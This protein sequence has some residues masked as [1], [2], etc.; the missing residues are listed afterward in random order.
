[1]QIYLI[2]HLKTQG[3][4]E[5]RYIGR[6]DE[7][8][9]QTPEQDAR[10]REM[11][12]TLPDVEKVVASPMK[13][14][15]E[16]AELLYTRIPLVTC[17]NLRECDF[18]LFENKN[19]EELKSVPEYQIWLDSEGILPFP[20]GEA[21]EE[22]CHRCTEGFE[23]ML[24][25]CIDDCCRSVAFVVHGGTI[26]AILE[27]FSGGGESFYHW[28]VENGGGYRMTVDEEEWKSGRKRLREIEKL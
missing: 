17:E 10:I 24:E 1:M 4:L 11:K 25:Q 7:S 6:T 28:Q 18:G 12:G 23:Q 2:R 27:R 8:L 26:M 21:H 16:T 9:V 15:L 19:Y 5:R 3:N 13:R 20:G 14:C 22:F